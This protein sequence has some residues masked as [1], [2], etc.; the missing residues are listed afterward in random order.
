[1]LGE[2]TYC[3]LVVTGGNCKYIK[4]KTCA[5]YFQ[6][7]KL[8]LDVRRILKWFTCVFILS[9]FC[10]CTELFRQHTV[11]PQWDGLQG[12]RFPIILLPL[13]GWQHQKKVLTLE[14]LEHLNTTR[15][16]S[17]MWCEEG[18]KIRSQKFCQ[19]VEYSAKR[20]IS[21]SA[22]VVFSIMV[23]PVQQ[24]CPRNTLRCFANVSDVLITKWTGFPKDVMEGMNRGLI[25]LAKQFKQVRGRVGWS[26][27]F[28][29]TFIKPYRCRYNKHS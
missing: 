19:T 13:S 25:Y 28:N 16:G 15:D 12:K 1:M 4:M 20:Q 22:P 18:A 26:T 27:F 29:L 8:K 5:F 9:T 11:H 10:F 14:H 3:T 23:L 2:V 24:S 7:N 21:C 6:A 17:T